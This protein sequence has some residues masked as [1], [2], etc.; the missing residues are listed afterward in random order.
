[1]L[2]LSCP[3]ALLACDMAVLDAQLGLLPVRVVEMHLMNELF[4]SIES[5]LRSP[6]L[7]DT[8]PGGPRTVHPAMEALAFPV[9]LLGRCTQD[10]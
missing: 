8:F 10:G 6:C 7:M 4:C 9:P 2:L 1:M 5:S 3:T